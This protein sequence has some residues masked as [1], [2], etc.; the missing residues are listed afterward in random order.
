MN[1]LN[2]WAP[3]WRYHYSKTP[4]YPDLFHWTVCAQYISINFISVDSELFLSKQIFFTTVFRL[5]NSLRKMYYFTTG[6]RNLLH[7]YCTFAAV[8]LHFCVLWQRNIKHS[9]SSSVLTFLH[10]V[11]K[12][13]VHNVMSSPINVKQY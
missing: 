8:H 9:N 13:V 12:V 1:I 10:S 7:I 6:S 2:S 4:L 5:M 11:S 3:Y